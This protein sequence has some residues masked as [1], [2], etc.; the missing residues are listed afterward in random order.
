MRI[1]CGV[2]LLLLLKMLGMLI[3][4]RLWR[5]GCRYCVRS[6]VDCRSVNGDCCEHAIKA[7]LEV[8]AWRQAT[9]DIEELFVVD[10]SLSPWC[11][12]VQCLKNG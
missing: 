5:V 11:C 12:N 3:N 8:D 9:A 10:M 7:D 1:A 6:R 4:D 2:L